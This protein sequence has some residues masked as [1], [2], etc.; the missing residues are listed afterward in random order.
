MASVIRAVKVWIDD[1]FVAESNTT[2]VNNRL[3]VEI[4]LAREQVVS[5]G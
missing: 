5:E 2:G 3:E 4:G 1:V